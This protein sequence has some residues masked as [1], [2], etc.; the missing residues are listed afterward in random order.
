MSADLSGLVGD[1]LLLLRA[2]GYKL[3]TVPSTF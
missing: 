2:L 3:A 1:C